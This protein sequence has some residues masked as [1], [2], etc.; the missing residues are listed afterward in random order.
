MQDLR[1]VIIIIALIIISN[2]FYS[3][4]LAKPRRQ[5]HSKFWKEDMPLFQVEWLSTIPQFSVVMSLSN[6]APYTPIFTFF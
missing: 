3:L 4:F 2:E 1:E 6:Q 5:D